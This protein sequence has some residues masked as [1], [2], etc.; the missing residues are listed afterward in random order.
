MNFAIQHQIS[1]QNVSSDIHTLLE[2]SI[3][4]KRSSRLTRLLLKHEAS[5]DKVAC[6]SEK[7]MH[8]VLFA[9]MCDSRPSRRHQSYLNLLL[10]NGVHSRMISEEMHNLLS[11]C[12]K[13]VADHNIT[14]LLIRHETRWDQIE[15]QSLRVVLKA[16]FT[17]L[18]SSTRSKFLNRLSLIIDRRL[19]VSQNQSD[20]DQLI[21]RALSIR[22]IEL[23]IWEV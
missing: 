20:V 8:R 11:L 23:A 7:L 18:Q 1:F 3:A 2:N 4:M 12:F 13:K 17:K 14:Y 22:S 16:A 10:E 5:F 9:I 19:F 21:R 6:D 15:K